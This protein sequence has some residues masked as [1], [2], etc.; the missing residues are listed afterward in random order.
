[1]RKSPDKRLGS[2]ETDAIEVKKQRFFMVCICFD[3]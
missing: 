1:M 2:G 3:Y